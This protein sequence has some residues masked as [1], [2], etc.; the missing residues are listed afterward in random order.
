M[1]EPIVRLALVMGAGLLVLVVW[2]SRRSRVPG[3]RIV[4]TGFAPGLYLFSSRTCNDCATARQRL[5]GVAFTEIAWE[6]EPQT[7]ERLGIAD[8]PSTLVVSANGSG[9]WYRGVPR[10]VVR[11]K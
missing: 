11:T 3:R 4:D 2:L 7:F 10:S 6:E 9:T 8:V 1:D 5:A